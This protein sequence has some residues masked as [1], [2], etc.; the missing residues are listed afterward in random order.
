MQT[1]HE[2]KSWPLF[3][4]MLNGGIKHSEVRVNDRN[5]QIGDELLFREWNPHT[6][7]YSGRTCQRQ[8]INMYACQGLEPGYVVMDLTKAM[9]ATLEKAHA[10]ITPAQTEAVMD[11][12]FPT[13]FSAS[14]LAIKGR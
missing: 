11:S 8:I 5:F 13:E 7:A 4:G 12:L 14:E 2:L 6:Q 1:I 10:E 3:F 9:P